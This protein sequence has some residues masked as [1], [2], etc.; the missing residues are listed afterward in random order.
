MA[1]VKRSLVLS[2]GVLMMAGQ[3]VVYAG[4]LRQLW[5]INLK[6]ALQS[7]PISQPAAFPIYLVRFSPDGQKLLAVVDWYKSGDVAKSRLALIQTQHPD[8]PPAQFEASGRLSEETAG[9]DSFGWSPDGKIIHAGTS[10]IRIA[11][12]N[13]CDLP[14]PTVLISN[15][16]LIQRGANPPSPQSVRSW[17]DASDEYLRAVRRYRDYGGPPPPPEPPKPPSSSDMHFTFYDTDCQPQEKWEVP[18]AWSI[19]DAS[20]DRGLLSVYLP[21]DGYWKAETLIVDPLARKVLQRWPWSSGPFGRSADSGPYGQFADSG[22]AICAGSS[23]VAAPGGRAP[24]VCWDVDTGQKIGEAPTASGG[25]PI[26]TAA[27]ASRIV[28]TDWGRRKIPFSV[29]GE[30]EPVLKGRVVWDFRSGKELV[31][32]RPDFQSYEN[33]VHKA[34]NEPFRFAISPDGEYIAEGGNGIIRLYKIEP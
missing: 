14:W 3:P 32:W 13:T 5:E 27:H 4:S 28:A 6:K 19:R 9:A 24:V 22:K 31:K 1:Q 25:Y 7:T 11:D 10:T 12:G 29:E 26:A 23:T 20:A 18:E 16:S 17:I 34:V 15:D 2:L 21:T 33:L 8:V 30:Y